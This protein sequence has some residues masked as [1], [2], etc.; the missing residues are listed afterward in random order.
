MKRKVT[1]VEGIT[2]QKVKDKRGLIQKHIENKGKT[3]GLFFR[4]GVKR[5]EKDV[6]VSLLN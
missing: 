2:G 5:G 1:S 6:S 3:S 4:E